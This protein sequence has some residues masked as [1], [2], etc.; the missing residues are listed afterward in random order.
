MGSKALS[1]ILVQGFR[2]K[3]GNTR[4]WKNEAK[5]R[6]FLDEAACK[7]GNLP[8]AQDQKI[9]L[10]IMF[11]KDILEPHGFAERCAADDKSTVAYSFCPIQNS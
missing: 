9:Y 3:G 7:P 5:G 1:C 8:G 10:L 4:R 6:K 11:E 2:F